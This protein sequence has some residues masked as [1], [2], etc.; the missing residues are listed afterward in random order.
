M[1]I[2]FSFRLISDKFESGEKEE[3]LILIAAAVLATFI[4]FTSKAFDIS[5]PNL[6]FKGLTQSDIFSFKLFLGSFFSGAI[7]S[8]IAWY[9]ISKLNK[10]SEIALRIILLMIIFMVVLFGDV[11]VTSW[12]VESN[13]GFNKALIPNVSFVIGVLGY[14]IFNYKT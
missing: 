9:I 11:Y 10:S 4:Y 5:I 1:A 8:L 12:G 14:I 7:G 2:F 13:S 3:G 6:I